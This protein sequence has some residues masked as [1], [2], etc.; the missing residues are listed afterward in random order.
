MRIEKPIELKNVN[1]YE[2]LSVRYPPKPLLGTIK[3][4]DIHLF[5]NGEQ[6]FGQKYISHL[7]DL[8]QRRYGILPEDLFKVDPKRREVDD[9]RIYDEEFLLELVIY[10]MDGIPYAK[11][12]EAKTGGAFYF[13]A[14][15]YPNLS[16]ETIRVYVHRY[17]TPIVTMTAERVGRASKLQAF[18]YPESKKTEEYLREIL[19]ILKLGIFE[20]LDC[21]SRSLPGYYHALKSDKLESMYNVDTFVDFLHLFVVAGRSP[22]EI[23]KIKRNTGITSNEISVAF[24]KILTTEAKNRIK[25]FKKKGILAVEKF[26]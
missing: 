18:L 17:F 8:I 14:K 5:E 1:D 9:V 13:D 21:D 24:S 4:K 7:Y 15:L 16:G 25:M 10:I 3:P 23:L 26:A 22:V 2:Y 19:D 6:V 11:I 12:A 20:L